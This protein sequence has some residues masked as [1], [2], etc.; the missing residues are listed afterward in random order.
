M[1]SKNCVYYTLKFSITQF[2]NNVCFL[3]KDK[4]QT[5]IQL[6]AT[7]SAELTSS[8]ANKNHYLPALRNLSFQIKAQVGSNSEQEQIKSNSYSRDADTADQI[9]GKTRQGGTRIL[10]L[11]SG[12]DML[13]SATGRFHTTVGRTLLHKEGVREAPLLTCLIIR[14]C[15]N[16]KH[17][18]WTD[19]HYHY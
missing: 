16:T 1:I 18:L 17:K 12:P 19:S 14:S 10:S 7:K 15:S 13:S 3:L 4:V 11:E 2:Q 6:W 5:A 8:L 9:G